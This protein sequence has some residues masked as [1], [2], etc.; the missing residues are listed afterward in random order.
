MEDGASE[1]HI[2]PKKENNPKQ[3]K[4]K[5]AQQADSKIYVKPMS[6]NKPKN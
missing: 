2:I 6:K 4:S 5:Y 1:V 3:V